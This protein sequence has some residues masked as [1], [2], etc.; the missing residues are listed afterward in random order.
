M[1]RSAF[2]TDAEGGELPRARCPTCGAGVPPHRVLIDWEQRTIQFAGHTVKARR[3]VVVVLAALLRR[4]PAAITQRK[5]ATALWGTNVSHRSLATLRVNIMHLRTALRRLNIIVTSFVERGNTRYRIV[6]PDA[7]VVRTM[8][9][10]SRLAAQ[11]RRRA[12]RLA[13][14]ELERPPAP[15]SI[16]ETLLDSERETRK[17]LRRGDKDAGE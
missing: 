8:M 7:A 9:N 15:K 13:E 2:I 1:P 6:L 5:L 17:I 12:T 16:R 4:Y 10:K 14:R 11:E 3:A